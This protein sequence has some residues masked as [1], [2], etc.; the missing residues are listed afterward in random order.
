MQN[1]RNSA[2]GKECSCNSQTMPVNI[3]TA[4]AACAN[5]QLDVLKTSLPSALRVAE[6]HCSQASGWLLD[7]WCYL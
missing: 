6:H 4:S 5:C 1:V 7:A 2:V 3:C